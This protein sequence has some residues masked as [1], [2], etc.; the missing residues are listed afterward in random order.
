MSRVYRYR[1]RR[2]GVGRYLVEEQYRVL[3]LW[4]RWRV[5]S[6]RLQLQGEY[7]TAAKAMED[8]TRQAKRLHLS[9]AVEDLES[10]FLAIQLSIKGQVRTAR[11]QARRADERARNLRRIGRDP[12]RRGG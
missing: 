3:F 1:I 9:V 11:K 4:E 7:A 10:R 6:R 5:G 12:D 2:I 8:I